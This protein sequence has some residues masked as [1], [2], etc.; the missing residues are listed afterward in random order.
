M[1]SSIV[2]PQQFVPRVANTQTE[3]DRRMMQIL[4]HAK[5]HHWMPGGP[6]GTRLPFY[7]LTKTIQGLPVG[8]VVSLTE[9]HVLLQ[10][11]VFRI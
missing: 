3:E 2:H 6:F 10:R 7:E 1:I 9:L 5:F 8:T 4:D 11:A